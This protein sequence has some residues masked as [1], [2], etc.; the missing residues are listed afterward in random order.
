[1]TSVEEDREQWLA[2]VA[3]LLAGRDQQD[4]DHILRV[5]YTS[6]Q[7]SPHKPPF[8]VPERAEVLAA[9]SGVETARMRQFQQKLW[10][11]LLVTVGED[12][13]EDAIDS[14]WPIIVGEIE[15]QCSRR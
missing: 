2:R 11:V 13:V 12:K 7:E 3:K 8:E 5:S 6:L 14:I 9:T 1:M 15:W 10:A 4:K